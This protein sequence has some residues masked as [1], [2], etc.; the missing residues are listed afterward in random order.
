MG[1]PSLRQQAYIK[2][3]AGIVNGGLPKGTV[4]SEGELSRK[5]D[6]SRTPIRAALQQLEL[7]GYLR[8]AAKHGIIILDSSARR[9]SDLLETIISQVWYAFSVSS[10]SKREHL[11]RLAQAESVRF[12][13]LLQSQADAYALVQFEHTLLDKLIALCTN[14]EMT[15]TF[16]SACNR[17]FW[18][19][20]ISR[21]QAPFSAETQACISNLIDTLSAELDVFLAALFDYLSLLKRTWH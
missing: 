10:L 3:L 12:H 13:E 19:Q 15:K 9:V 8:I 6:M 17:L 18:Q 21:W 1:N 2:I 5:L 4:T 20:N 7:E 11:Q 16:H 14:D